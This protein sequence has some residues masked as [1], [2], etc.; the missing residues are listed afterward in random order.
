[1]CS[2]DSK[3]WR[4]R[5]WGRRVGVMWRLGGEVNMGLR[6]AGRVD[7]LAQSPRVFWLESVWPMDCFYP[8][9]LSLWFLIS[10]DHQILCY[11]GW[12]FFNKYVSLNIKDI[13]RKLF[14]KRKTNT[15]TTTTKIQPP[16][17]GNSWAQ[18]RDAAPSR[19]PDRLSALCFLLPSLLL[20]PLL[21]INCS[22][23]KSHFLHLLCLL[24]HPRF[25]LFTWLFPT[26]LSEGCLPFIPSRE[27]STA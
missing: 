14:K 12:I 26:H 17:L 8:S 6:K 25:L 21:Q 7:D 27:T 24:P 9:P 13:F 2:I 22:C 23:W 4:D 5:C 16:S 18:V 1:M 19:C 3:G 15:Q 20:S 11:L 10:A